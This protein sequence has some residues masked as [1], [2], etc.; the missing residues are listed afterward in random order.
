M[1][2]YKILND[3]KANTIIEL[4]GYYTLD[5]LDFIIRESE[6]K[7][8]CEHEFDGVWLTDDLEGYRCALCG[9]E[10]IELD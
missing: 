3:Q 9:F 5:D 8:Y 2:P 4:H 1:N 6:F 10:T 7:A